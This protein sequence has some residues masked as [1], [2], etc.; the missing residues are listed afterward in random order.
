MGSSAP[1]YT[2]ITGEQ[3][4]EIFRLASQLY[5]KK[6]PHESNFTT[7][8]DI[9]NYYEITHSGAKSGLIGSKKRGYSFFQG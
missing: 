8:V 6:Y 5:F 3:D 2:K 7:R 4:T 1:G 9:R